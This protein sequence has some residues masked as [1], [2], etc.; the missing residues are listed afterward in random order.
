MTAPAPIVTALDLVEIAVLAALGAL[1]PAYWGAAPVDTVGRLRLPESQGTHLA[2]VFVAQ[3]QDGGGQEAP[4]L[5]SRGWTGLV[6]VKVF[7][8][9]PVAAR[10][11]YA[12]AADAMAALT[13]P[14]G[15]ALTADW[16]RPL[17]LPTIDRIIARAGVWELT[18][19]RVG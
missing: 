12:L 4:L 8:A 5:G 15:Y 2:R 1:G 10:T 9:S 6:T 3:H 14:A 13:S 11:G 16:R 18:L 17:D 7:S 19:R